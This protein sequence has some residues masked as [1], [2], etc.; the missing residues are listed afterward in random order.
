[1]P[2][3]RVPQMGHPALTE[4]SDVYECD[5]QRVGCDS[6]HYR[7][8]VAVADQGLIRHGSQRIV[9]GGVQLDCYRVSRRGDVFAQRPMN[10][11]HDAKRQ[12]VLYGQGDT[13]LHQPASRKQ[14]TDVV[15]HRHLPWNRFGAADSGV[16]DR[17]VGYRRLHRERRRDV[18]S[19]GCPLGPSNDKGRVSHRHAVG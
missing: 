14:L 10:L 17:R 15:S 19:L 9:V 4:L 12:G 3:V 13:G 11:W 6:E 2:E 7:V 16:D 8:E 5:P 1:M 18:R